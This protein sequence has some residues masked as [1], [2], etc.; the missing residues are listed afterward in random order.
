M[1]CQVLAS[2]G[3]D[4]PDC[5]QESPVNM[6]EIKTETLGFLRC[7]TDRA[8]SSASSITPRGEILGCWL[9]PSPSVARLLSSH[10]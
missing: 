4:S 7:I 8:L 6:L 9:D 2:I 1:F 10:S 5:Q 3:F